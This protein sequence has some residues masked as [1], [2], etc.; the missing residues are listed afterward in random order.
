MSAP[1]THPFLT[2]NFDVRSLD[3]RTWL[4]LGETMSKCQHLAGS[5]LN[6]ASARELAAVYLARGAQATTAIEGNTLSSA[7][8]DKIVRDGSANLPESRQYLEKEVQNV[9]SAVREIDAAL[10]AGQQIPL[11]ARRLLH[12]NA[13][14]LEGIPDKPEVVPGQF[15]QHDVAVGTYKAPHWTEVP[16]LIDEFLR[17]LETLRGDLRADRP[18]EERLVSAVVSAV[19]AHLYIA[20]IHPFGNGN[21]R[22]ARLVE[23]LILSESGI[24]PLVSTNLLSNYYNKT[25]NLYYLRL[26]EAQRSVAAFVKYA[27]L[28]LVDELRDQIDFVRKESERVH[29]ESLIHETFGGLPATKARDRQ[30]KLALALPSD[31][32]V[33]PTQIQDLSVELARL[34]AQCGER[35]PARDLNDLVKLG[36][37]EK[38]GARKYRGKQEVVKALMPPVA[39]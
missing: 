33:T 25:R 27:V 14:V 30:R 23:V 26:D 22:V 8:V 29:W 21:G 11:D 15:R 20:W 1:D 34:Y 35:T 7:E 6:P 36:L 31:D 10:H 32:A 16:A 24:V 19:L 13:V 18:D 3:Q 9:L 37:A 4:L 38:A 17:W 12:F 5:P 2:F 28:G 39:H